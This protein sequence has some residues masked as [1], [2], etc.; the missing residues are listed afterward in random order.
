[1]IRLLS[2]IVVGLLVGCAESPIRIGMMDAEDLVQVATASLC[3]D[4]STFHRHD[5]KIR[6]ELE[7]RII[8]TSREWKAIE[9]HRIFIGMSE[10]AF[11]CSWPP[12]D[13]F[14]LDSAF[15]SKEGPWGVRVVYE[16]GL[17]ALH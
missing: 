16:Y 1:M 12:P 6:P 11:G 5:A 17:G 7:R 13:V 9:Q 4:Y 8:F 14:D 2:T 3:F 15:V 10:S